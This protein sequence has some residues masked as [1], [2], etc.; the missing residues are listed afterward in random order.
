MAVA[1]PARARRPGRARRVVLGRA[2]TGGLALGL[3]F[4]W[5]SLT[6]T[7]MPRTWV[8][9]A[10]ISALCAL[11][12][13][14]LG[15]VGARLVHVVL[16]RLDRVPGP[17][18]R[19]RVRQG[20]GVVAVGAVVV[21][22]PLWVRWQDEQRARV[23]LDDLSPVVALPMAVLT[24]VLVA[25]LVPVGRVVGAAVRKLDRWNRR[26]LPSVLARPLT[27]ALVLALTVLV[28]RDL[29]FARF[30][31]W[32]G[33]T[34]GQLDAGTNEGT[35]QPTAA[36]VSGSPGSLVAWDDLGVQ[37]RDFVAGATTLDELRAFHGAG[38]DV[39]EPVR[40][41]AGLR[42][43]DTVRE[44]AR[45]AVAELER[46][47][48]FDREVLVVATATGSGW[49]DPDAA[50][51][52]EQLHAGDTAIVSMQ[53]SYL[54]SWIAF[55][56]DLELASEAGAVLYDEVY[57]A[58]RARPAADRP[59]LVAFGLSLG[60]FGAEAAFAGRDAETSLANMT[61]RT[62]GVLLVGA[63]HANP[64]LRQLTAGRDDGSP[65]WAPV[66]DGGEVVRFRTRDPDHAEPDG[67]W[68]EPRVLYVQ[69]PSDPVTH[70][71][72]D[73]L[74]AEP[75]WM[76]DPRGYDVPDR[77]GWFPVVTFVQGVFDL[78]AGFGAPPGYGHDYR[79]DYVDAWADVAPR[80]GWTPADTA[81][82]EDHL[83]E[84]P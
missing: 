11:L 16:R 36:T 80:A 39:R 69:H 57:D 65:A 41:Y 52:V 70:W 15:T 14:A 67:P 50:E 26:H 74:W 45:L 27:V 82:L 58:W 75:D 43:A 8:T 73:W 33:T 4:W 21:G 49:I 19:H 59:R 77:G 17:E 54:P 63:A 37:G 40:A 78:M 32:A 6:P 46:T 68:A 83:F 23:E 29:L 66:V 30:T 9:Q 2:T 48:A 51:A 12:G 28:S 72:A 71:S 79:L 53:Y 1:A 25:V 42:S 31:S 38:A 81:R 64:V 62:D 60:S 76:D 84:R 10:A 35:E 3:V 44:R 55:V 34:F 7:L 5:R 56:T 20:L 22:L 18:L 24:V 13:Y 47:A 61:A